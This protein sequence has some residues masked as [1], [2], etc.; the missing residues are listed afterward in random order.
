MARFSYLPTSKLHPSCVGNHGGD[1]QVWQHLQHTL[2]LLLGKPVLH[3]L[4]ECLYEFYRH[5]SGIV[6]QCA[7][8]LWTW[9]RH[10]IR[11]PTPVCYQK[12]RFSASLILFAL[13]QHLNRHFFFKSSSITIGVIRDSLLGLQIISQERIPEGSIFPLLPL[14]LVEPSYTE[15]WSPTVDAHGPFG[16]V[17]RF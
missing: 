2:A 3:N 13:G 10:S 11:L 8:S 16:H 7:L 1:D 9:P 12:P 4:Y 15:R 6:K 14:L 5:D 17:K